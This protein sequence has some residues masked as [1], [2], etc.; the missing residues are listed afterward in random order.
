MWKLIKTEFSY[1]IFIISVIFGIKIVSSILILTFPPRENFL[2]VMVYEWLMIPLPA[3]LILVLINNLIREKRDRLYAKLP[4]KLSYTAASRIAFLLL[5]LILLQMLNSMTIFL[6]GI[7]N[8]HDSLTIYAAQASNS[9]DAGSSVMI[10]VT[11]V[12]LIDIF[13]SLRKG[14]LVLRFSEAFVLSA[15]LILFGLVFN[16]YTHQVLWDISEL[17]NFQNKLTGILYMLVTPNTFALFGIFLSVLA[18]IF[19]RMRRSYV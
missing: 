11:I 2:V 12:I 3:V 18:V 19:Y 1:N 7:L 9:N 4:V 8:L 16:K 6:G 17:S 13:F 5:P 14:T 10:I 15:L